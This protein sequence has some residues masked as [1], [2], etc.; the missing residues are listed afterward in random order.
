MV[1]VF[2]VTKSGR[3]LIIKEVKTLPVA[4]KYVEELNEND[5]IQVGNE[6]YPF[7]AFYYFY[8]KIK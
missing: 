1:V 4:K 3:P 5:Y 6:T 2:G 7:N 8:Y